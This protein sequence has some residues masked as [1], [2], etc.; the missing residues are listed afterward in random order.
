M[1]SRSAMEVRCAGRV[2]LD[3]HTRDILTRESS[4]RHGFREGGLS[5]RHGQSLASAR[6]ACTLAESEGTASFATSCSRDD[7]HVHSI[8]LHGSIFSNDPTA[9]P[10]PSSF[11]RPPNSTHDM[12]TE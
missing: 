8:T 1:I 10:I 5:L 12:N 2:V 7:F 11:W 9:V 6:G 4:E 3:S